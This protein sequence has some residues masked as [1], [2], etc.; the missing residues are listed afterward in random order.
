MEGTGVTFEPQ[1]DL[2]NASVHG[3]RVMLNVKAPFVP[4]DLSG[5]IW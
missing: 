2:R 4:F 5:Q 1:P 3:M